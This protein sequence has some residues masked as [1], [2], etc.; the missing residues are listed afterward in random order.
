MRGTRQWLAVLAICAMAPACGKKKKSES[1][2]EPEESSGKV[3][4]TSANGPVAPDRASISLPSN[5]PKYLNPLLALQHNRANM[6]IFEG[7]VGLDAKLEPVPRLAESWEMTE[8]G[9][10]ITF[11]LRKGVTWSDGKPFTG[12]DVAFTF[13]ALRS[14]TELPTLWAAFMVDVESVETPDPHIVVVKYSKPYAPA[15]VTWTMGILP[16]HAYGTGDLSEVE[17][18]TKPIGTGPYKMSRWDIG[19]GMVLVANENWWHGE[20]KIGTVNLVFGVDD[21]FAA[22]R[23]GRLDFIDIRDTNAWLNQATMPEFKR[24]AEQTSVPGSLYRVI[25]WNTERAPFND[26]KVRQAMTHALNRRRVVDD[27]LVGWGQ[28]LAAPMFPNMFGLD[29]SLAPHKFDLAAAKELL[30]NKKLKFT[31]L[32]L[33][34]QKT[35]VN[36]EMLA[37]W[38]SDLQRGLGVELTVEYLPYPEWKARVADKRDFDAAFFGWLPEIPDP[39]PY[40]LLHSSQVETGRQNFAGYKSPEAD[41]LLEEAREISDRDKRRQLY[42]E[43]TAILN[44]DLPYTVAYAPFRHYAWSRRLRGVDPADVGEFARFPGLA[45]WWVEEPAN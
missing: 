13:Q 37:R 7:L 16:E 44:R 33:E 21:Q 1:D 5:E 19:K 23:S 43:L 27:L 36:E 10:T 18:N 15:L 42:E 34:S 31:L 14:V 41:K 4:E 45:T 25:A 8:D 20:P 39:D 22:L 6:L 28:L 2:K 35:Q 32:T 29:R 12:K 17:A 30:G 3:T 40:N 38:R 24:A 11:K 26:V 9:K